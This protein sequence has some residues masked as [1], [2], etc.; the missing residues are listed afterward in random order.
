MS[1]GFMQYLLLTIALLH[2]GSSSRHSE[3]KP[4]SIKIGDGVQYVT[5]KNRCFIITIYSTRNSL[6]YVVI[7][8]YICFPSNNI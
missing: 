6:Y 5:P 2:T 7:Y 3:D 8:I 1:F 4:N